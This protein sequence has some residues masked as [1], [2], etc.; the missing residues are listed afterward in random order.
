[1]TE[2]DVSTM[3]SQIPHSHSVRHGATDAETPNN[4]SCLATEREHQKSL[5]NKR[6]TFT[7]LQHNVLPDR[8]KKIFA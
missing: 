5:I 8:V 3:S 7:K 1:M 4:G 2:F 6:I